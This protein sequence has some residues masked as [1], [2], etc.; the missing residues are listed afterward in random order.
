MRSVA[1]NADAMVRGF[2]AG[3]ERCTPA[4]AAPLAMPSYLQHALLGLAL[5]SVPGGILGAWIALPQTAFY[6]H[7]VGTA[8]F[9]GLVVAGPWGVPAQR[10]AL[11]AST[12]CWRPGSSAWCAGAGW[13]R[14]RQPACCSGSARWRSASCS[15]PDV[16]GSGASVDRLLFGN[17]FEV[18]GTD[19]ALTAAVALL[20]LLVSAVCFR[21]WLATAFDPGSARSLGVRE[22]AA[23]QALL[24]LVALAVVVAVDAV[25]ALLVGALFVVPAA[26]VA[27]VAGRVGALLAGAVGLTLCE[28][29]GLWI[30]RIPTC[31]WPGGR[32][33]GRRPVHDGDGVAGEGP[34]GDRRAGLVRVD[35]LSGGYGGERLALRDVGFAVRAGESLAVL[36][37]NCGGGKTT[38][39]RALLDELPVRRGG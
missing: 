9:P 18:T 8:A 13:R 10:A 21:A 38:L 3:R 15:P 4:D 16:Y 37:P 5:L 28:V 32:R 6:T 22:R 33:P 1:A 24:G 19:L 25:G 29:A 27:L 30:A 2:T 11:G 20:T 34:R 35:G 17:V 31:S 39:L 12:R 7:A 14:T 23:D 36:G 26:T